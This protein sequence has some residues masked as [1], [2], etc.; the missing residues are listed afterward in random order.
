MKRRLDILDTH[1]IRAPFASRERSA[2]EWV[3]RI[4][5]GILTEGKDGG[6]VALAGDRQE[7]R[8]ILSNYVYEHLFYTLNKNELRL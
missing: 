5:V 2:P 8:H 1:S 7:D 3:S 4:S 6:G